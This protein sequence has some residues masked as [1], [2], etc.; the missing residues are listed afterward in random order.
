MV[1]T[2]L[3]ISPSQHQVLIVLVASIGT[4]SILSSLLIL[5]HYLAYRKTR[6]KSYKPVVYLSI[7]IIGSDATALGF[8]RG[9]SCRVYSVLQTY[10]ILSS[11]AWSSILARTISL[12]RVQRSRLSQTLTRLN[13]FADQNP[14]NIRNIERIRMVALHVIAWGVP[15]VISISITLVSAD[16]PMSDWCW[17]NYGSDEGVVANTSTTALPLLFYLPLLS[18]LLYNTFVLSGLWMK[19]IQQCC[20]SEDNDEAFVRANCR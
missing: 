18:S 3:S 4:L 9:G 16:E 17:F 10:F 14:L 5:Y 2:G 15:L 1:S 20:P 8:L 12:V 6:D 11:L 13:S 7:A 19:R